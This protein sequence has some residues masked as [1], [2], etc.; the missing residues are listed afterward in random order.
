MFPDIIP[1]A[2]NKRKLFKQERN[3]FSYCL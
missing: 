1:M 3:S 2:L